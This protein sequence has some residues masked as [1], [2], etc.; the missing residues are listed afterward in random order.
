MAF[1]LSDRPVR[2]AALGLIVNSLKRHS[3][4]RF[5]VAWTQIGSWQ[6][7]QL[8]DA[9]LSRNVMAR[10][11][12]GFVASARASWGAKRWTYLL[13]PVANQFMPQN[14]QLCSALMIVGLGTDHVG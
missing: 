6:N 7:A 10:R 13:D 12:V 11:C 2:Q 3:T 9:V 8:L 1:S 5:W 4:Y 14:F